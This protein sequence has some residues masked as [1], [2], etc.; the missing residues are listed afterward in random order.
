MIVKV[1]EI[2]SVG[3][4]KSFLKA[5]WSLKSFVSQDKN[6]LYDDYGGVFG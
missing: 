2:K 5:E 6:Y 4:Q 3:K 1:R